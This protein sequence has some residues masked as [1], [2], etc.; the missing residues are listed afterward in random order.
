MLDNF[1]LKLLA[2]PIQILSKIAR[3]IQVEGRKIKG[4]KKQWKMYIRMWFIG[5]VETGCLHAKDSVSNP[6][7][8]SKLWAE[9]DSDVQDLYKKNSERV[10][11]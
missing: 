9:F 3:T 2:Q 11:V 7:G 4:D 8:Q 10:L 1:S 6:S 5:W